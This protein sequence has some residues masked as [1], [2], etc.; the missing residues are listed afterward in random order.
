MLQYMPIEEASY[1][2]GPAL[3][4]TCWLVWPLPQGINSIRN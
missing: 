1:A 3:T 4:R 2:F